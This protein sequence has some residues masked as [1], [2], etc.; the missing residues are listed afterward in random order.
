[1]YTSLQ[2]RPVLV[3]ARSITRPGTPRP[4]KDRGAH[5]S[6]LPG[7]PPHGVTLPREMVRST[8]TNNSR[9]QRGTL[10]LSDLSTV[11]TGSLVLRRAPPQPHAEPADGCA[12]QRL[13]EA[14]TRVKA[15]FAAGLGAHSHTAAHSASTLLPA[16][17]EACSAGSC[18]RQHVAPGRATCLFCG[19]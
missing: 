15:G 8:C 12:L 19:P 9:M 16:K 2:A 18:H 17:A 3:K 13:H 5:A 11:V 10:L 4:S 1:M 14:H 6:A 7:Q